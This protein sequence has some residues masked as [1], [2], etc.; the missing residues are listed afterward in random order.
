MSSFAEENLK[1]NEAVICVTTSS[2]MG[3]NGCSD[4]VQNEIILRV[5]TLN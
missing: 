3:D 4:S 5:A 2:R 1:V